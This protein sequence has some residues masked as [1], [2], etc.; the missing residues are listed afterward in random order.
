[1][2]TGIE[3]PN[4]PELP[5]PRYMPHPPPKKYVANI[6]YPSH[7]EGCFKYSEAVYENPSKT[8]RFATDVPDIV[9]L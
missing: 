4:V 3:L 8:V 9:G 1:M 7:L 5:S 2:L 6:R